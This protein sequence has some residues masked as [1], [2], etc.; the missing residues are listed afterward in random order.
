MGTEIFRRIDIIWIRTFLFL[1]GCRL[2]VKGKEHFEKGVNYVVTCNHNS[3]L[4]VP[5]LTPFIP[6][7]NKTIAKIE[8]S[9]IPIF[10]IVYKRGSVLVDRKDKASR[11]KSFLAM[12]QVLNQNMHMSLYPE[13]TRNRS[14][15]PLADFKSGAFRL[16]MDMQ[17]DI[18]PALIFNTK[19]ILPTDKGMY[20]N[21]GK[22]EL[23]FLPPVK[24]SEFP[25]FEA[26][27]DHVH[28]VMEHYFLEHTGSHK[29][30]S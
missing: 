17:K 12:R 20:F 28:N 9:R 10:G 30:H 15:R 14:G 6:G 18:I 19:N 26:L 7:P 24:T 13:G 1:A 25:S 27:R 11:Q 23:H 29:N 2:R 22:I 3:M 8:M 4:D 5:V 21:P 16:A